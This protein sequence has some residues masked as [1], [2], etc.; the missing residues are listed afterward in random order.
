MRKILS[1]IV[2]LMLSASAAW[3]GDYTV[4][5]TAANNSSA[6]LSEIGYS[7][8]SDVTSLKVTGTLNGYDFMALRNKLPNLQRLD[9]G[10]ASIVANDYPYYKEETVS[11]DEFPAYL[12]YACGIT[13][14]LLS[15]KLPKGITSVGV[16]AFEG[17]SKLT[18]IEFVSDIKTIQSNAF[19][20]CSALLSISLPLS[21]EYIESGAFQSCTKLATINFPN[22]L[23]SIGSNAFNGCNALTSLSFTGSLQSIGANAFQNCRN[24]LNVQLS[25]RITSLGDN[26]FYG[27]DKMSEV[28]LPS[29]LSSLGKN[30][31]Y[32]CNSLRKVSAYAAQP[33]KMDQSTF[34]AAI[35]DVCDLCV[36]KTSY[37]AYFWDTQWSQFSHLI[38]TDF[39]YENLYISNTGQDYILDESTGSISGNPEIAVLSQAG[40]I[41]KDD[42]N[43]QA[44]EIILM[45]D[46]THSGSIVATNNLNANYFTM[47]LTAKKNK[48]YFFSVPYDAP[49]SGIRCS[50]NWV[51]RAYDGFS[52]AKN[53]SGWVNFTGTTLRTGVGYIF[54]TD[55]DGTLYITMP[56]PTFT[57]RDVSLEIKQ[58]VSSP[59]PDSE[60]SWNYLGNPFPTYYC[61]A[62]LDYTAPITVRN[63]ETNTYVAYSS[64]DDTYHLAPFQ[65]FFVQKPASTNRLTFHGEKRRTYNMGQDR[66]YLSAPAMH[67]SVAR[68]LVDLVVYNADNQMAADRTRVVFNESMQYTYDMGADAAKFTSAEALFELYTLD[69]EGVAYAINERPQLGDVVLAYR[70]SQPGAYKLRA[71]RADVAVELYDS[72]EDTVVLLTD[73]GYTFTTEAG[74]FTDRFKVSLAS[75]GIESLRTVAE[76]SAVYDLSGCPTNLSSPG[77]YIRVENGKFNKMIIR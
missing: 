32:G 41:I 50:G 59:R 15:V 25:N 20:S 11:E 3:A 22:T 6:L 16:S 36:P 35:F 44:S 30:A 40:V 24:I 61:I 52:R 10:G 68:R 42:I 33:V 23:I 21:V 12:F 9:L 65:S 37:S 55:T 74:E 60:A 38:A 64:S 76:P 72:V 47:Q 29:S 75:S 4:S 46:G 31:F 57:L 8:L 2:V 62:D 13:D 71:D 56:S 19:K 28:S 1:S 63:V 7:N 73:E 77:T 39:V 53:G 18:T 67:G 48:W 69:A 27:D 70:A 5:V 43:Q 51:I 54:Q 66:E 45:S 26:V 17:C 58:Y 49:T 14:G 34:P